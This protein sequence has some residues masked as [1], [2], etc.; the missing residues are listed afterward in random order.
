MQRRAPGGRAGARE[1]AL[2]G[3]LV[4]R[5]GGLG[6]TLLL[7]PALHALRRAHPGARIELAGVREFA[8]VLAEAAV[9]DAALSSEDLRLWALRTGGAGGAALRARLCVYGR[10][11]ADDPA[12]AVLAD[13]GMDVRVFAVEPG[14]EA[15]M[16]EQLLARIVPD[17]RRYGA[18][19]HGFAGRGPARAAATGPVALAPGSGSPRKCWPQ[20][21]WLQL[22]ERLHAAGRA[23]VG[24]VGPVEQ[25]RDDPRRW[26][27]TVPVGWWAGLSAAELARRLAPVRAFVGND[28]G[29]THLAAACGVPTVAVFGPTDPRVWAPVG[30]HVQVFGRPGAAPPDADVGAVLAAVLRAG[31]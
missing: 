20:Q 9:V 5:R 1:A 19:R 21:R 6:D 26:P 29:V 4:V 25:E 13:E 23:L 18:P 11:L 8:E 28:S 17:W 22:G 12:V 30:P 7:L 31:S 16:G 15:P 2:S 10:I 14:G 3:V 27:W 24:V